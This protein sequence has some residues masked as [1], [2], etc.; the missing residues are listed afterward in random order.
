MSFSDLKF[1]KKPTKNLTNFYSETKKWSNQQSKGTFLYIIQ[2]WLHIW[3]INVLKTPYGAVILWFDHFLD[4]WAEICQIF[5]W[6]FGK[7]TNIK[8]TFWNYLTFT[9]CNSR[10]NMFPHHAWHCDIQVFSGSQVPFSIRF[11]I[12]VLKWRVSQN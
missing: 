11:S 1:S 12:S 7:F 5:S 10:W 8:K 3:A 4:S 6:F 9:V 2:L